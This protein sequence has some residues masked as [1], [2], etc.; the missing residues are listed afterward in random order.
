MS[1]SSGSPSSTSSATPTPTPS[2]IAGTPCT[3]EKKTQVLAGQTYVCA[4]DQ[5]GKLSW[6][7]SATAQ[8]LNYQR[9][10]AAKA[11]ADKAAADKA[12]ADKAAAD[13]AAADKAA[14]DQ[15]AA[16]KAA[17][18]KAA[19]E[20]AAA[21]AAA[22]AAP[23]APPAAAAPS[24]CD[25]NYAGACVPI[26]SDVDC[27]GGKG[28]GPSYVRGPVTVIGSDIYGLDNDHDGIGCEK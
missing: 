20:Q 22:N 15:A 6:L 13:K 28:N 27:A 9:A 7:D 12:A 1:S 19:A 5:A 26:D 3:T 18:D 17:A 14:A 21:N 8:A 25:P 23:K 10:A 11:A 4:V 16:A 2:K 24:G